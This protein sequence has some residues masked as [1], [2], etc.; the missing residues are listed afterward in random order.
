MKFWTSGESERNPGNHHLQLSVKGCKEGQ[1]D[2]AWT[3]GLM[4]DVNEWTW[5][6][7]NKVWR[8]PEDR[9]AWKN[10]VSRVAINGLNTPAF[11]IYMRYIYMHSGF[12]TLCTI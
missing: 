9:V 6:S 11:K 5:L 1:K 10:C 3:T 2:R 4:D 7:L 8:D 12:I